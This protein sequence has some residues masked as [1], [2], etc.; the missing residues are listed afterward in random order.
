MTQTATNPQTGEKLA[1]IGGEW[2]PI[3]QSAT[4]NKGVKAYLV[5]NKW[6]TDEAPTQSPEDAAALASEIK[7]MRAAPVNDVQTTPPQVAKIP[8][9]KKMFTQA[10]VDERREENPNL[11]M[12][13]DFI[14]G[15]SNTARGAVNAMKGSKPTLRQLIT[16]EQPFALGDALFPN[17]I[18]GV[19]TD[20]PNSMASLAGNIVDP[21]AWMLAGGVTKAKPLANVAGQTIRNY[22]KNIAAGGATGGILGG[23]SEDGDAETGTILGMAIPAVAQPVLGAV[24]KGAGVVGNVIGPHLPKIDPAALLPQAIQARARGVLPLWLQGETTGAERAAGRIASNEKIGNI[25]EVKALLAKAKP[26][27]TAGQ[28]AE[29]AKSA[30]FS[31][32]QKL[33]E[34]T[35]G[36][37][38]AASDASQK[39]G[40]KA[41]LGR[42]SG[43]GTQADALLARRG[44]K[45]KMGKTIGP[46]MDAELNAANLGTIDT[47]KITKGLSGI[48]ENPMGAGNKTAQRVVK[49][50]ARQIDDWTEKNGGVI[51]AKALQG[52]RKNAVDDAVRRALKSSDPSTVQKETALLTSEVKPL[53][54]EAITSAGGTKWKSVL[55]EWARGEQAIKRKELGS[56]AADLLETNPKKLISLGKNN[57]PELVEKTLG[58]GKVKIGPKHPIAKVA[59]AL[60]K[61]A[62]VD[63][64]AEAGRP[65]ALKI[66]RAEETLPTAPGL[67]DWR[68]TAA[69]KVMRELSG[70]GG[71]NVNETLGDLILT[72]PKRLSKIMGLVTPDENKMMIDAILQRA[73]IIGSSKQGDKK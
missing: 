73:A 58:R 29:S 14:A 22:G 63:R 32:L 42:V 30:E 28:A 7:R 9:Y 55:K 25:D 13:T 44:V 53:I 69:N 43:G 17:K 51:D 31:A 21:A 68:V 37:T 65:T 34:L 52:L 38:K 60:E 3:A 33:T 23:L 35:Q 57:E 6:I 70:K 72:D 39:A 26:G 5:D 10:Y 40:L 49:D 1:L 15:L 50:I 47:S 4:N 62:E 36:S 8:D 56:I 67:I 71:A 19:R 2:K 61:N 18:D 45:A 11:A 54:D 48:A 24:K 27:Q 66:L 16:G 59:S 12:A 41:E 20:N 46:K 64:L